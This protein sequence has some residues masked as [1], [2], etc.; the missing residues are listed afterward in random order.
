MSTLLVSALAFWLTGLA[1][2][3]ALVLAHLYGL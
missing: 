2:S 1:A 3:A